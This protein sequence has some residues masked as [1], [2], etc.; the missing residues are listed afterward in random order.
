MSL[1]SRCR[2]ACGDSWQLGCRTEGAPGD[3]GTCGQDE[4][5]KAGAQ[6]TYDAA[7]P[8]PSSPSLQLSVPGSSRTP[9]LPSP[10]RSSHHGSRCVLGAW[11]VC[12]RSVGSGCLLCCRFVA[13]LRLQWLWKNRRTEP[14][15]RRFCCS[16][17][18]SVGQEAH[19]HSRN[20]V[21]GLGLLICSPFTLR[22]V[23]PLSHQHKMTGAR[24]RDRCV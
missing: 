19:E 24:L 6:V 2:L 12:G 22:R 17:V 9:H 23:S 16:F 21:C 7:D 5:S 18:T 1:K 8:S 4:K 15:N 14:T 13:H 10:L 3:Q 20:T 11:L